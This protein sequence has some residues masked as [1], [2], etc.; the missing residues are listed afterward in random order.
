MTNLTALPFV[1]EVFRKSGAAF[2]T[3]LAVNAFLRNKSADVR[4][5]ILAT[6]VVAVL[7]AALAYP[8]LPRW[9]AVVPAW[10]P[11]NETA[12]ATQTAP[13]TQIVVASAPDP[14]VSAETQRSAPTSPKN[15][16]PQILP[17]LWLA[18]TTLLLTRFFVGLYGLRRLRR[19]STQAPIYSGSDSIEILQSDAIAAPVTWGVSR[20]VILLPTGF[21]DLPSD[22]RD[23]VLCHEQ[24]H[25]RNHDFLLRCLAE[26]VRAI[27]WFQPLAWLV[28]RQL[29]EEQELSSDDCVLESG[30]KPSAYAKLLMDWDLTP[31]GAN[32]LTAVGMAHRSCLKRRLYALLDQNLR[33]DRVTTAPALATGLIGLAMALP[34]AAITF[35]RQTPPVPVTPPAVQAVAAG[36]IAA[37]ANPQSPARRESRI[38]LAQARPNPTPPAPPPQPPPP[39]P[40]PP[41]SA[42]PQATAQFSPRAHH[43]VTTALVIVDATVKDQNGRTIDNLAANDF[44][45]LEDDRT[46]HISVFE[47]Q[48]GPSNYYVLGYY[49]TNNKLDG[50]YRKTAVMLK[51]VTAKVDYRAGYYAGYPPSPAP[52]IT[53]DGVTDM[54]MARRMTPAMLIANRD[55]EYSEEARKAKYSGTVQ[56]LVSIDAAGLITDAMVEKSLGMGL[57]EKAIEAVRRWRFKPA[58][59]NGQPVASQID[60]DVLFKLF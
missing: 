28:R 22:C 57:D 26:F 7:A 44:V 51:N 43:V 12:E 53:V 39:P 5:L 54:D 15:S 21:E 34:L 16:A 60:V 58:S 17:W 10:F 38:Q 50:S 9:A 6:A 45:V 19:S 29:R 40:A 37:V 14:V 49:T 11:S 47:F 24:A 31:S 2:G 42:N 41:A 56:L 59:L 13:V 35:T 20:H 30:G 55:P 46:Q 36:T 33:R 23:A 32:T 3:A 8:L 25:I 48:Q 4:R 18:G 52:T 1:L 27:V